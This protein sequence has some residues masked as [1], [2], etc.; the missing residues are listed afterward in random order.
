MPLPRLDPDI[1][2]S[3]SPKWSTSS[4]NPDSQSPERRPPA[5]SRLMAQAHEDSTADSSTSSPS[6]STVHPN[7]AD[8][9]PMASRWP[10]GSSSPNCSTSVRATRWMS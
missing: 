1:A 8:R 6:A 7:S 2:A 4:S 5:Q 9:P 10:A 3:R